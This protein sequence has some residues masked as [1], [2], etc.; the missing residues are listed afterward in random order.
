VRT[1]RP[2]SCSAQASEFCRLLACSL[3]M[4][5]LAVVCAAGAADPVA[6]T[7]RAMLSQAWPYLAAYWPY[8][9]Q[10]LP[11]K[12]GSTDAYSASELH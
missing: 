5:R 11:Q 8:E 12:N 2:Y 9:T 3:A 7:C 1:S 10:G 4:S 6:Q